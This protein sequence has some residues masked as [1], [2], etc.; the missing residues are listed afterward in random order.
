MIQR[1]NAAGAESKAEA[2]AEAE[3]ETPVSGRVALI[4]GD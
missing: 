3:H 4:R 1:N 2:E